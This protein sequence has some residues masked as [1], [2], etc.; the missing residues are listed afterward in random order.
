MASLLCAGAA[1]E[2]AAG[3][4]S[5]EGVWSFNGGAVDIVGQPNGMLVGIV[6]VPTKFTLCVHPVGE[7][8]WI[9]MKCPDRASNC[10]EVPPGLPTTGP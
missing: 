1:T 8:M 7:K 6:T 4:A 5:I 10:R 2:G 3:A 9:E